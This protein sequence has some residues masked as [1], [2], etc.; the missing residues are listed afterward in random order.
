MSAI[1]GLYLTDDSIMP[2]GQRMSTIIS[3]LRSNVNATWLQHRFG[4][5]PHVQR[6]PSARPSPRFLLSITSLIL[7]SPCYC[8]NETDLRNS[9]VSHPLR[10]SDFHVPGQNYG[11]QPGGQVGGGGGSV[12]VPGGRGPP[13]LGGIQSIGQS[14]AGIP[15]GGPA[16]GQAP[17]QAPA[18]GVQSQQPQGPAPTTTPPVH[19][20]SPQEMGKQA[21]LQ[22]QPQPLTQVYAPTQTRQTSQGYYQP[23]PRPQQ[24]RNIS[25]RGGQ[26]GSGTQVVG[27]SGV[28]GSGGQP[29]T[30]YHPTG[31]PV[32]TGTMYQVPNLHPGPHQ[33]S[34]YMNNQMPLQFPG[35]P[36]RHQTHQNQTP[37]Y[38][39]F[40]HSALLTQNMFGY[41]PAPTPSHAYFWSTGQPPNAPL[42][43][44]RASANAV[45]GGSQHVAGPLAGAQGAPVVPQGTLQ[46]STQQ[47]QPLPP[48]GISLS[49]PDVYPGHNGGV[50]NATNTTTKYRKPRG[51]NAITD[52]VNPLTG[53]NISHEIYKD[54]DASQSGE[55]S[56]RETPQPQNNGADA[57]RADFAARVAKA[58]ATEEPESGSPVPASAPEA[59]ATSQNATTQSLSNVQT[60]SSNDTSSQCNTG[61]PTPTQ[62][63][64]T[65]PALCSHSLSGQLV[66]SCAIKTES[67]PLQLPVKEFQPRSEIKALVVEE[68]S[69]GAPPVISKDNIPAQL[70][71][72]ASGTG[73]AS[74]ASNAT[75][76][77]TNIGTTATLAVPDPDPPASSTLAPQTPL[78]PV[79]VTVT[80]TNLSDLPQPS[81]TAP[82]ANP[83]P[84]R[85]PFPNLS[86]KTSSSP[87]RRKSQTHAPPHAP[88]Q[89]SS[90]PL[91]AREKSLSS[92]GTTPTPAQNQT[93]H[94]HQ[95]ANGDATGEKSDL[96]TAPRN[97]VQQKSTDGKA[98]QKQKSKNKLKPRDLNRRGAEKEG[99]DMDAFVNTTVPLTKT[100]IKQQDNKEVLPAKDS[101]KEPSREITKDMKEKDNYES[102]K[103]KDI[104]SI[105]PKTET[106]VSSAPVPKESSILA[107]AP[108][109]EKPPPSN[110]EILVEAPAKT[111]D[112]IKTNVCNAQAKSVPNDVVDHAKVKEE[113]DMEAIV[114]QKNEENSKV[115]ALQ[116]AKEEEEESPVSAMPSQ[117]S[118]KVCKLEPPLKYTYKDDQWSPINK[119]G[120]KVYDRE[121]LMMLQDDPHS[122]IKPPNLPDLDVVLKDST[123]P[124]STVDLRPFKDTNIGRHEALYP[125][126]GKSTVTTRMPPP[127]RK[128]HPAGKPKPT[129]PNMIHVSLSLRE[130][131]KLRE[132]ENAWKPARLKPTSMTEEEAKTEVLYKKVR[133]VLNKLTPQNF[134]T[135]LEQVRSLTIDT[136]ERLQGVINLVFEKAV[137]EPSFS[138]EYALLCKD[139]AQIQVTSSERYS[140]RQEGGGVSFKKL[141][142]G[143]CQK[144]FEKNPADEVARAA[145]LKEIEEC[146][147]PDKKKDLQVAL[148]EE[149][150]RI[151]IKSVGNIRFIGE[152]YK[153]GMLIGRIMHRCIKHLLDQN[154]EESL[155]CVCKLLT[156]IGKD[157]ESTGSTEH[158][159][160]MQSYFDKMQSIVAR[161]GQSK[162]SSRIRFMLQDVIDLRANKWV[163]RRVDVNPKTIDQI[164]KEAESERLDSQLNNTPMNTPRKDDR[165]SDRKRNRGVGPTD[166]GGWSQPVG[167]MR[168]QTYSLDTAK[169]KNKPPPM[170]DLQLG[171][172]NVYVWK[173]LPT[174]SNSNKFACLE[175]MSTLDQDKRIMPPQ[176]SASRSIGPREYGRDYKSSYDG[177]SSRNG[178]HQLSSAS[179]SRESSLLDSTQGQNVSLPM[180]LLKFASQ[181][182]TSS[183]HKPPMS[184]EEFM[185]ALNSTLK[186]FLKNPIIDKTAL[187]V[188]QT[189]EGQ[190]SKFVHESILNVLEKVPLDRDLVSQLL[191]HL[192]THKMLTLQQFRNGFAQVLEAV[193]DL[194]IDIPKIWTYL[195]EVL[196][197]PLEQDVIKLSD[198][199]P[200]FESLRSQGY[201]GKLLVELL[202]KLSQNK[203]SMWVADKWD[204]SGLVLNNIVD[205]ERE[206]VDRIIKDYN[207]EFVKADYKKTEGSIGN[208]FSLQQ[209]HEELRRLMKE[210]T[211]DEI[212]SWITANVGN[213]VKEPKFIRV[214]TTA[215]LETSIETVNDRWNLNPDTLTGLQQLIRRFVDANALL[216]LQCLYAIQTHMTKLQYPYGL[217][218]GIM[219]RL[220]EDNIISTDAFLTWE[221]SKEPGERAGHAV[222]VKALT[223][224][225][226]N[227]KEGDDAS[228][229]EDVSTSV[230]ED[231]C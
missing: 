155:E 91:A 25:H 62:S 220:W 26:G 124:R 142:I 45:S 152:L 110:K 188:Q 136:E 28:G 150:R 74:N 146:T 103:E 113:M 143:R 163:P 58:F 101:N 40:P 208:Q 14:P 122:K 73:S 175:N 1:P 56:N 118:G 205:T 72:P 34:V 79:A 9:S 226:T 121:F 171:S 180:S 21:H 68:A 218:P 169:L 20:P 133:S 149:D 8:P 230:N 209:I 51:Q 199:K 119:S 49:Q 5:C 127:N 22:P 39:P 211:F 225:F 88:Q 183:S 36:Q 202:N 99:T 47:A 102:A 111:E 132:T 187:H 117:D 18:P 145:K 165:N 42:S 114:A 204:Q 7:A 186:E 173:S 69:T 170:D 84:A 229:V 54:N 198:L 61:P 135:L 217:L 194:I 162:I 104:M 38:A 125:A 98:M 81:V 75:A 195:A 141:I 6:W 65:L 172:R 215:I 189:F 64:P 213:Q 10:G 140:E 166:E 55:S 228:S 60:N 160:E 31:L 13:P 89:P 43:I 53:E 33:Q 76:V 85:E 120:K 27:M 50:T 200:T 203:G 93:E 123:K 2:P 66:D 167:R 90:A 192:M 223:S 138:V 185:K 67:K 231:R 29:A 52:I 174:K 17:P 70:G 137:D 129:K 130:D 32:Q 15:P 44:N 206:N 100:E 37:Y 41:A 153:Q 3:L 207:L 116:S 159:E 87:P 97:D 224:F 191:T 219:M 94:H 24:P 181:S 190:M 46:Q 214:L 201:A 23:G 112:N 177:R 4:P 176:V 179:S 105:G 86:T 227:L 147:D 164:Q 168:Q 196:S 35:P 156:T 92:R 154:D 197:Y 71:T 109:I 80:S 107:Q 57:I 12:G 19:T 83:V 182:S 126:F 95:K 48:M 139:L 134:S 106:E 221:T 59:A 30:M 178:S 78:L 16:G 108:I 96:E 212:C 158:Y 157:L 210:N 161:R 151:R 82:S 184:E 216:E 144:E 63:A 222:A 11:T 131:V 115:S 193:D 148:E 128:S 77:T